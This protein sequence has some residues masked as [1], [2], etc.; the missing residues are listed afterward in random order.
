LFTSHIADDIFLKGCAFLNYTGTQQEWYIDK[1]M[2]I[3]GT[4]TT[5]EEERDE[6]MY[7]IFKINTGRKK[8]KQHHDSRM[9][10]VQKKK[11]GSILLREVFLNLCETAAQ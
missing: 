8:K 9:T 6:D 2:S 11:I 5:T 3:R 10:L 7:K 4:V 1:N